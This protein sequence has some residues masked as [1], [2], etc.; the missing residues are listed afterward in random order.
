MAMGHC[1]C[2]SINKHLFAVS[3]EPLAQL[4]GQGRP[5][6]CQTISRDHPNL[7]HQLFSTGSR[8]PT[9]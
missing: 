4:G 8:L 9:L 5:G 3:S 6:S 1:L 7:Q 2:K